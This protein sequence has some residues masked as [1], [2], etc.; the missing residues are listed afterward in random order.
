MRYFELSFETNYDE[1]YEEKHYATIDDDNYFLTDDDIS[2]YEPFIDEFEEFCEDLK[3]SCLTPKEE[4]HYHDSCYWY[5]E[6]I[7]EEEYLELTTE[8]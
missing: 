6:E 2:C 1:L 5:W 8:A 7:S 4:E 3:P